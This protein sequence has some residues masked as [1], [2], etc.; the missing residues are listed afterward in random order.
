LEDSLTHGILSKLINEKHWNCVF[1]MRLILLFLKQAQKVTSLEETIQSGIGL[2]EKILIAQ[3]WVDVRSQ[4]TAFSYWPNLKR[5]LCF[6]AAEYSSK[7][8]LVAALFQK[9]LIGESAEERND[10]LI[11]EFSDESPILK[12]ILTQAV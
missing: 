7:T 2:V 3:P 1:L 10:G 11:K 6:F 12:D 4:E 8:P 5:G 9:Y